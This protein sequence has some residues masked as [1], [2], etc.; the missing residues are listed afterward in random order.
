MGAIIGNQNF[1]ILCLFFFGEGGGRFPTCYCIRVSQFKNYFRLILRR[2]FRCAFL[3]L[4]AY[5]MTRS[6]KK[7]PQLSRCF[8]QLVPIFLHLSYYYKSIVIRQIN[9]WK[10]VFSHLVLCSWIARHL[11]STKFSKRRSFSAENVWRT[12]SDLLSIGS[13]AWNIRSS[14][15]LCCC[16]SDF[17]KVGHLEQCICM[18]KFFWC[19]ETVQK[20][21]ICG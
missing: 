16:R 7:R 18:T 4:F 12:I 1:F 2:V 14:G 15:V 13:L 3:G 9:M 19:E 17:P 10:L 5:V 20:F 11:I 8:L 6:L 21:V